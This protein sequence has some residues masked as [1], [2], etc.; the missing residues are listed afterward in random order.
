MTRKKR[1]TNLLLLSLL[2][3]LLVGAT[4]AVMTL[5]PDEEAEEE[6]VNEGVEILTLKEEDAS[7]INWTVN[8]ETFAMDKEGEEWVL[9]SDPA[10][11]LDQEHMSAIFTD[12]GGL[13]SYNT[14][15]NVTDLAEYGLDEP[16]AVIHVDD[17][18]KNLV[19]I[20][21]GD[22]APMDSLRYLSLGDG[23]V[24]LVSN[25]ILSNYNVTLDDLL[26]METIPAFSNHQ[27]IVVQSQD[28]ILE[29]SCQTNSQ[30]GEKTSVWY[31]GEQEL[32][33]A[34]VESFCDNISSLAW[35]GCEAYG[36]TDFAP[37]GLDAPL[38]YATVNWYDE[39]AA[40]DQSFTLEIGADKDESSCYARISGSDIVY[41]IDSA[42][43]DALAQ[44]T[45]DD[46]LADETAAE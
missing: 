35:L 46:L 14:L 11:P 21:L 42:V 31:H 22:A 23:N 34:K 7:A 33:A 5:T 24:Y 12:L 16:T 40:A 6:S 19:T 17:A 38:L 18:N 9:S 10:F 27:S 45:A 26:A 8:G 4:V 20:Q 43:R 37:Y 28:N 15:E 3:L 41:S 36:V 30:N 2:L 25:A 1:G 32:D 13:L 29:L 39:T 44:T